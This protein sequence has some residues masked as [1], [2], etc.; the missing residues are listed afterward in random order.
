MNKKYDNNN[1]IIAS[2]AYFLQGFGK[3]FQRMIKQI[4]SIG[5]VGVKLNGLETNFFLIGKGLRQGDPSS[6]HLV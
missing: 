1:I 6:P 3:N 4:T 2:R 5:S